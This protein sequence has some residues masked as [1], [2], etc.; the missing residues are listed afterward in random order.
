M[1]ESL[2]DKETTLLRVVFYSKGGGAEHLG[3]KH[4]QL[5]NSD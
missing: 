1:N 5:H 2:N 4:V 3:E